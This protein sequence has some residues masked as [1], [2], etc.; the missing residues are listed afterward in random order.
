MPLL[1]FA[2][3]LVG[4]HH[5]SEEST[6]LTQDETACAEASARLG[7]SAC[8]P[9]IS[10]NDTFQA[11]T[12]ASSSVDQLRVGKYLMPAVEDARL[13]QLFLDVNSFQLHYDF[14][15]NAFPDDFAGLSIDEYEDLILNPETREF[16]AGTYSAYIDD[17]GGFYG[18]T[19]WD[20]PSDDATTVTEAQVEDAW[21][22][23]Q[24]RFEIGE[25]SFV[26]NSN[27]QQDTV[28]SWG[29]TAFPI[30]NPAEVDYEAYNPGV[31]YGYLRLY[32][33]DDFVTAS[34]V[35]AYGYQDIV[36]IE[37]APEDL[38]RVVSGIVTGTRQG[39]LS[40]L[41]VRSAARGTPNCYIREP[42]STLSAWKDQ[43]VRFEC[44][45]STWTAS[46]AT[47]EEATAWWESIRPDPVEICLPN[48]SET[49][50]PGLLELPTDTKE[51][52]STNLCTYGSKG[53]NLATLY[54]RIDPQ[55]QLDGFVIPFSYYDQF[56]HTGT[57]QVDLGDGL[58]SHTFA[59]T[60]DAWHND[61]IFLTDA[62]E[63][64]ARLSALRDA[65]Y[66]VPVDAGV[67]ELLRQRIVAVWG[68]ENVMVRFRSSSNAEDGLI[69]SGAGLYESASVCV[70]DD[71]DGDSQGPSRCDP[72]NESEHTVSDGIRQVWGSL[73]KLS[74]WEERDWYGIAHENVVMGVLCDTRYNDEL[75]NVVA[76]S[77]NPTAA[78]DDRYLINAQ[79]GDLE[80]VS[81]EPGVYPEKELL[82]IENG[83][84]TIIDRVSESSEVSLV[85]TDAQLNTLG[86][87]FSDI[88]DV[89]PVDY[90]VPD[91]SD[92][93]WDTEWKFLADG[94][95]MVK[96]IRPYLR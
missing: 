65:F 64:S 34:E 55:F 63:R 17:Q 26:P 3:L 93:M 11:M 95:L 81:A 38:T 47:S 79:E 62:T 75:A 21:T 33:L 36:V 59:D 83:V 49:A 19:L 16:Y 54:Q 77:G 37:E 45:D 40:H 90:E 76:F 74:A 88:V 1:L 85:L 41:S 91:G 86:A 52:R 51:Q 5:G 25:L 2:G 80:V 43:L 22:Q 73:W 9:R 42:L 71:L 61:P 92:L 66:T 31:G 68:S 12:V 53:S 87:A 15:V 6:P 24:E 23:L 89:Y 69:F 56:I 30:R 10:D 46:A 96:Q 48:R 8:V 14:L 28:P 29:D 39:S 84:V 20:D 67:I 58:Q 4:C 60:L 70:A 82:T 44:G 32:N 94:R 35:A 18:F 78:G 27:N 72:D 13:P 50:M 57:W 7:Y